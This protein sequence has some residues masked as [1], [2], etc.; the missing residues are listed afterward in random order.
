MSLDELGLKHGTDKSTA[1]HGYLPVYEELL[2]ARFGGRQELLRSKGSLLELG[3]FDGA[4]MRMWREWLPEWQITGLDIEPKAPIDGV[5]FVQ[6]GQDSSRVAQ[7]VAEEH[8]PFDVIVDDA[9]HLSPLTIRSFEL[10]WPELRAGGIYL[11]ED[12]HVSYHAAWQGNTNPDAPGSRGQTIM[13]YLRQLADAVHLG[14]G[15][16]GPHSRHVRYR[17]VASV[18]YWPG[19]AAITKKV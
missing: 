9:S 15:G 19:F 18:A 12:L 6:G 16:A 5:D 10:Y 4:S 3:W 11:I 7:R 13:Q 8:G 17:D 1:A 2:C 14:H